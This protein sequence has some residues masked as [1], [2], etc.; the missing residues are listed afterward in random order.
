[1]SRSVFLSLLSR[2]PHSGNWWYW[3][4]G[5]AEW[6]RTSALVLGD[7]SEKQYGEAAA[8]APAHRPAAT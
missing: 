6:Q 3:A 4:E 7:V 1:M 2:D 5:M 8:T